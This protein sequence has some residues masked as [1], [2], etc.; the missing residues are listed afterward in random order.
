VTSLDFRDRLGR[1]AARAEISLTPETVEALELYFR[2]LAK[3]NAK[4]N[5]TALPLE[6][7]T[8]ETF[9]RLLIEPLAAARC[10]TDRHQEWV[11]LGSGGGSPAIPL[12]LVKPSIGLTMVESKVRKAAFLREAIRVLGLKATTVADVR[13]EEYAS[14]AE[15]VS[16]TDMV[17]VRA[18][19][20]DK[21]L[22]SVAS[23]LLM[24]GGRLLLF[25]PTTAAVSAPGFAHIETIALTQSPAYLAICERMFHV[26]QT[27]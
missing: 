22:F 17:T 14:R 1:R 27:H 6:Q 8:E 2:L 25:C 5:L 23:R 24:P 4:I 15:A 3:W 7:P 21:A 26:E 18:V 12:K 9:D 13:F 11:D 16:S 19:R 20:A 10:I